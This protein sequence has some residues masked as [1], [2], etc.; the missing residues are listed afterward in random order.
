M[1]DRARAV[2]AANAQQ[3]TRTTDDKSQV[4]TSDSAQQSAVARARSVG[5][6]EREEGTLPSFPK[7][8]FLNCG[9]INL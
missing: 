6:S 8:K 1:R 5:V 7:I 3:Q 2:W 4:V 9:T